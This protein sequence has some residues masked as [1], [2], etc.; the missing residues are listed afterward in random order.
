[1]EI[2][3]NL[4]NSIFTVVTAL[5]LFSLL[6]ACEPAVTSQ[7]PT[8]TVPAV[9]SQT[10][11]SS[12]PATTTAAPT[13]V[14]APAKPQGEVVV[15]LNSFGNESFLPWTSDL[16]AGQ[17]NC[18]V[19]DILIYWDEVNKKFI[20]GLAESWE[21]SPDGKTFT[22]HL[23]KGIQYQDGWGEFTS[24]DVKYNFQMQAGPSSQGKTAQTR[25]IES[26]DT[27]DPYTLVI[28]FRSPYPTF[29]MEFSYGN[30]GTNHGFPS[31]KYV[32]TVGEDE[33]GLKPISTGPYKLKEMRSGD[34]I[35]FEA[36]DTHWRVVPEF[37]Y[38]TLRQ[39]PELSTAIA[40]LK[41]KEI[42]MAAV[43]SEQLPGLKAAGI[44]TE[45]SSVPGTAISLSWGGLL[46]P[47]DYRYKPDYHNKDPWVDVRVRKA[48]A[49]SIDRQAICNSIFAG[50]AVPIGV[51]LV[52]AGTNKYQ[53]PYDPAA[54]KQL[55]IDAGYPK[56]FTFK[57]LSFA[58]RG[59]PEAP[60][61][62]EALAY[63][64]QQI[65]LDPQ[66]VAVEQTIYARDRSFAK[67]AGTLGAQ[68]IAPGADMLEKA[69]TFLIPGSP[70]AL[71][72][73]EGSW[74]II[75]E[76]SA[77]ITVEERAAYLDKLN[78][79]LF[80]NVGPLPLVQVSY[81]FAWNAEKVSPFPHTAAS[82]PYYVEYF[83]H[84]QPLNTFRLFT[85]WP[86]R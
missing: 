64:W 51:P 39:V 10:T 35:K 83:R 75:K 49:I 11:T 31:K 27:P 62:M 58:M 65:G 76:G 20:P 67:T 29:Y 9:T 82:A 72:M 26:M 80:D 74:A 46:I 70:A 16:A 56:G 41:T 48:M 25:A 22:Y 2:K 21:L 85:P 78:Q 24:E 6:A 7:A 45:I 53:Y 52:S 40:M 33:A 4:L 84:A 55:L 28:H 79:Y 32:E 61:V 50:G 71:F 59:V 37:K 38:L 3:K 86:G 1:M 66:L 19:Y 47:A 15:A 34:Y 57:I 73:D 69:N 8:T 13:T 54:A 23:R 5:C 30:G 77:K 44:G 60:R 81:A 68:T 36:A 18:I 43:T 42:D 17:I 12:A 14:A 63:Y